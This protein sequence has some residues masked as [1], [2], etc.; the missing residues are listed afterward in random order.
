MVVELKYAGTQY[1]IHIDRYQFIP[2]RL[3]GYNKIEKSKDF[4]KPTFKELGFHTTMG[5]A[6]NEIIQDA[7]GGSDERIS[8]EEYVA[9]IE[10]A[11]DQI[12]NT[13]ELQ[14]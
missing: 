3:I 7:D 2:K 10:S 8:L 9:R 11:M 1:E 4:G 13:S 12:N 5:R 14:F 6:L